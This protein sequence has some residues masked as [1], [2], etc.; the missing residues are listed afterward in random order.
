MGLCIV[1]LAGGEDSWDNFPVS[2]LGDEI[3][4]GGSPSAT[5]TDSNKC[6]ST[7][8]IWRWIWYSIDNKLFSLYNKYPTG[9]SL[10]FYCFWIPNKDN[11]HNHKRKY[12][13]CCWCNFEVCSKHFKEIKR[14]CGFSSNWILLYF[15]T[16][17]VFVC[18]R[19]DISHF[20]HI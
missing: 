4:L 13:E 10:F 20:S 19:R 6:K 16:V 1:V 18:H 7:I 3:W 12:Q 5:E 11:S 15:P 14:N 8:L 9:K 17:R 2:K